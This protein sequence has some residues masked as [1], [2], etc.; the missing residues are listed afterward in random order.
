MARPIV[1]TDVGDVG[2]HIQDG[3][4][5]FVVPV[6]DVEQMADRL[7]RLALEPDRR[8]TMGL[9]SR[10]TAVAFAPQTIADLTLDIYQRV[11]AFPRDKEM[12]EKDGSGGK[13]S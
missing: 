13:V 1:S 7:R 8:E 11:L 2:R 9:A 12:G 4:S 10:E 5:G 6:G 3:E